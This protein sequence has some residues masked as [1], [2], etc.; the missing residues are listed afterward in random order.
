VN[1][2]KGIKIDSSVN[3]KGLEDLVKLLNGAGDALERVQKSSTVTT[4]DKSI[5]NPSKQTMEEL[6]SLFDVKGKSNTSGLG[7][8]FGDFNKDISKAFDAGIGD[9]MRRLKDQ[10]KDLKREMGDLSKEFGAVGEK[11]N[12]P[13]LSAED[14]TKLIQQQTDLGVGMA[15]SKMQMAEANRML[16]M[17]QPRGFLGGAS[18]QTGMNYGKMGLGAIAGAGTVL[19]M[20]DQAANLSGYSELATQNRYVMGALG[21]AMGGDPSTL[22][23]RKLGLGRE[24][25]T[26]GGDKTQT[27]INGVTGGIQWAT[28]NFMSALK[29][30]GSLAS[31]GLISKGSGIKTFDTVMMEKSM[32]ARNIDKEA[33][34]QTMSP[35]FQNMTQRSSLF[36]DYERQFGMGSSRAFASSAALRGRTNF[37]RAAEQTNMV[38][39]MGMDVSSYGADM[40]GSLEAGRRSGYS[41]NSRRSILRSIARGGRMDQSFSDF[42]N[43]VE[44]AGVGGNIVQQG[45]AG[46]YI[47][48]AYETGGGLSSFNDVAVT[49]NAIFNAGN[50]GGDVA[51]N[52]KSAA[53][54]VQNLNS[55]MASNGNLMGD[56]TTMVITKYTQDPYI[57]NTAK[58]M[59]SKGNIDGAAK[60]LAKTS[61][62]S[63]EKILKDLRATVENTIGV[64]NSMIGVGNLK[65]IGETFAEQAGMTNVSPD[66]M[67]KLGSAYARSGGTLGREEAQ[68][69]IAAESAVALGGGLQGGGAKVKE[70]F[71]SKDT[72]EQA[73][74]QYQSK[75]SEGETAITKALGQEITTVIADSFVQMGNFIL[76]QANKMGDKP[77]A[78]RASELNKTPDLGSKKTSPAS[79]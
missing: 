18:I 78:R 53:G 7:A 55:R 62:Q 10:I 65:S 30:I 49:S 56:M 68:G 37:A 73:E 46:D 70:G 79:K 1:I 12:D 45:M 26:T 47:A 3:V 14:R 27:M 16:F 77:E 34:G 60:L 67:I 2:Y 6:K 66:D 75:L 58:G 52:M 4:G 29:D 64:A 22:V 41:D 44:N 74:G 32:E 42:N 51:L 19:N 25:A 5:L 35:I 24:V 57:I 33:F 23:L 11:L 31:G 59:I 36:D 40:I 54:G 8:I 13:N 76:Q 39:G 71:T 50:M 9:A 69:I 15:G 43:L 17:N 61:G 28:G 48:N 20:Y 63:A 72:I 21:S 38:L